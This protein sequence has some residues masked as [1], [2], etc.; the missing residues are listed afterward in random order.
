MTLSCTTRDWQPVRPY[1]LISRLASDADMWM[2]R[3]LGWRR[4][5][6][7]GEED[8][9]EEEDGD[10]DEE[11]DEEEGCRSSLSLLSDGR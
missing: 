5:E 3:S 4:G 11:E 7:E 2:L 1:T 10:E 6:A 9:E 8:E